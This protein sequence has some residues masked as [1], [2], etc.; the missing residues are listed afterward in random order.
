MRSGKYHV[1]VEL[2]V[3]SRVREHEDEHDDRDALLGDTFFV[4][5]NFSDNRL[6]GFTISS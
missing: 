2:L 1:D 3:V 6:P 5:Y 4:C